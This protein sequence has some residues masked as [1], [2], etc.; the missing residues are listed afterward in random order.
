MA[1]YNH[2]AGMSNNAVDAYNK[3]RK[4]ISKI[5]KKEIGIDTDFLKF[6]IEKDEILTGGEFHHTG[7][8]WYNT[9]NFFDVEEIKEQVEQIK[10]SGKLD[11][12][13]SEFQEI[14]EKKEEDN[15]KKVVGKY[16]EFGGS[17]KRPKFLGH[18]DFSGILKNGWIFLD[19]GQKKKADGNHIEYKFVN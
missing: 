5:T 4:P 19:N 3:G 12:L 8:S 10:E 6:L 18:V 15:G 1:G 13:F 14:K 17:R 7:G 16:A 11:Q 2:G 9:T